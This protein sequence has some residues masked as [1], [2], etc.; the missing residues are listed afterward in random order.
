M[1][2]TAAPGA[3]VAM[4]KGDGPLKHVR[5]VGRGV[6]CIHAQQLA[7]LRDK[8]LRGGEFTGPGASPALDERECIRVWI[9]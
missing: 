7:Q 6:G 1:Q 3:A 2:V 5:L 9:L 8:A 4:A